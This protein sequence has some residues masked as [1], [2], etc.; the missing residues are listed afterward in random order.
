MSGNPSVAR[1]Y[2][3][4]WE[5]GR[6]IP[7]PYWRN[8]LSAA[9]GVP[10]GDL[11]RAAALSARMRSTPMAGR[12][13]KAVDE[14][15]K[16]DV[17]ES[18]R[19]HV[20][21]AGH[22]GGGTVDVGG[23][24]QVGGPLP[25]DGGD[26]D[27]R[28]RALFALMAATAASPVSESAETAR[29]ALSGSAHTGVTD[30]DC[31]TWERLAF[32]YAHEVGQLSSEQLLPGLLCDAR[33]LGLALD[34]ASAGL[35]PRLLRVAA[36]LAALT[37]IT[38]SNLDAGRDGRR[39]W[40]SAAQAADRSGDDWLASAVRGRQA[41]FSLYDEYPAA[42]T[43]ALADEAARIGKQRPILGVASALAARAQVCARTGRHQ[44]ARDE[45]AK[46]TRLYDRLPAETREDRVTQWGWSEQRLHHV[47]SHVHMFS[48]TLDA[49]ERAQEAAL[50]S[51]PERNYQGRSQIELHRAG[52]LLKAGDV[53]EGSRHL[54]TVLSALPTA[55]R[56]D[57]LVRQTAVTALSLA[58]AG[59]ADH[60]G[61][62][63]ARELLALT[64]GA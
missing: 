27:M 36:Q 47:S 2:V 28:R 39:W 6:R 30:R 40:R 20:A 38:L 35:R 11:D 52:S 44:E 41:V 9:L 32:D 25:I 57:A 43:L 59:T 42:S 24:A 15:G 17:A 21:A 29:Q 54:V 50:A 55:R 22:P 61:A 19:A 48:G 31:E 7:T 23:P 8:F 58:P 26:G 18:G 49:A 16:L 62:V 10:R 4:R 60:P 13:W 14:D 63:E 34:G 45:L 46:L 56:H 64:S 12:G 3:A 53:A 5:S 1:E 51:Y 37:A 33:D